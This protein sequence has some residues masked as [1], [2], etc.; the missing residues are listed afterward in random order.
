[1]KVVSAFAGWSF[2]ARLFQCV[3]F[4]FVV[5]LILF[6]YRWVVVVAKPFDVESHRRHAASRPVEEQGLQAQ[7][8]PWSD[9]EEPDHRQHRDSCIASMSAMEVPTIGLSGTKLVNRRRS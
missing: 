5:L 2:Y 8:P 1:M 4:A 7:R 3:F 9:L 6:A